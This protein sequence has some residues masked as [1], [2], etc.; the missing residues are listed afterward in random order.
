MGD[1]NFAFDRVSQAIDR[2][3]VLIAALLDDIKA[4]VT[5]LATIT[6]TQARGGGAAA[7]PAQGGGAAA[8]PAQGGGAAAPAQGGGAAAA[9]QPRVLPPINDPREQGILAMLGQRGLNEQPALAGA[10]TRLMAQRVLG[11]G[12]GAFA[13]GPMSPEA[14]ARDQADTREGQGATPRPQ[15]GGRRQAVGPDEDGL[16]PRSAIQF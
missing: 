7:A 2:R 8:A 1:L 11:A 13:G 9:A 3:R 12:E 4:M 5:S 14:A 15:Q 6:V 10:D 16:R